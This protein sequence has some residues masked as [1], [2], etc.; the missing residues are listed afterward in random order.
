MTK[1]KRECDIIS[2]RVRAGIIDELDNVIEKYNGIANPFPPETRAST[3]RSLID[4]AI[5]DNLHLIFEKLK[6]RK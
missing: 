3:V 5:E 2:V 4:F 1:K 6:N